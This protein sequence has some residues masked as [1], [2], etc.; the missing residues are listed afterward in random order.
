MDSGAK[1]YSNKANANGNGAGVYVTYG[2]TLNIKNG[3]E[4]YSNSADSGN[5]NGGGVYNAG[6]VYM[7]GGLVYDNSAQNGG[8][9]SGGGALIMSGG[10]I[11]KNSSGTSKPNTATNAGGAIY[12]SGSLNMSG[13]ALVCAGS[14]K[15]NDVYLP[16]GKTVYVANT[17]NEANVATVTLENWTRGTN[18]L[19]SLAE[20]RSKMVAAK[21]KFTLSKDPDGWNKL[22]D[23][24]TST[25][26]TRYAWIS[27]PMY[28]A[29]SSDR[30]VCSAPP[31]S[32]NNG[33]KT[34]PYGSIAA[35]LAAT[36]LA[37]VENTITIDGTLSAQ[38]I[39]STVTLPTGVTAVTLQGY[40]AADATT[41]AA[42]IDGG[43]TTSALA[44]GKSTTYTI[45][46][47]QITNGSAY[48]GGGINIAAGTVNLDS[49]ALV[50][51]NKAKA[52]GT[53]KGRGAGVY[54]DTDST[55]TMKN[56][57]GKTTSGEISSNTASLG[58]AV[59]MDWCGSSSGIK[60]YGAASIPKGSDEKND[61][62]VNAG[63]ADAVKPMISTYDTLTNSTIS[64]ITGNTYFYEENY[65]IIK[66][67]G[68]YN[69]GNAAKMEIKSEN[70]QDWTI[71]TSSSAGKLAKAKK[72]TSSNIASF[73]PT[74]STSYN[75]VIDS[76]VTSTQMKTFLEALCNEEVNTEK[77]KIAGNSI[78]DL[79]KS[80]LT[81]IA[82][83]NFG[84]S[85][86]RKYVEQTFA[87][88]ILPSTN[89]ASMLADYHVRECLSAK[90]YVVAPGSTTMC[91]D[92]NGVV[93][94]ADK[95]KII[96]YPAASTNT[97]YSWP[98]TV[99][100]V[101]GYAF[102]LVKNLTAVTI[103]N[104]VKTIGISAFQEAKITSVTV[105]SSVTSMGIQTF[106][107]CKQL[108]SATVNNTVV[109][110]R[111]FYGCSNLTNV[112]LYN[113]TK[114]TGASFEASG[115]KS[116]TIPATV[117]YIGLYGLTNNMTSL[118]FEKTDKWKSYN[119]VSDSSETY[120]GVI[121]STQLNAT[122]YNST[123]YNKV[124]KYGN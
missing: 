85:S 4:I 66:F 65:Q 44:I 70:S 54:L 98:N 91:T 62:Y 111:E 88:V 99:T 116:I 51:S 14:E 86:N 106:W 17:L 3:S 27:S 12:N 82:S 64:L 122:N 72:L 118:T 92:N 97:S 56:A 50:F 80:G 53:T 120:E 58:G 103:P 33:T 107:G 55:L 20:N 102:A 74:A 67:L 90:E 123:W 83:M 41:S 95:T 28:V 21:S 31:G 71:V 68:T 29:G 25:G 42:K 77:I 76:T 104:T 81:S 37:Q 49:G 40:K 87:K 105:P 30:V 112:I 101:A 1:V 78:L 108:T 47:L 121:S 9:F 124:L 94:N 115:L 5:I 6:T 119:Y 89:C 16:S 43:A 52:N 11:G 15:T 39:A 59:Y 7:T 38:T 36:D 23:S 8:A 110:Q 96:Y 113:V 2:A 60:L 69:H 114:I 24:T 61:I 13:D 48:D 22:D 18:F 32:G 117:T 10:A 84:N 34:S 57:T 93:Y 19:S 26:N 63:P 35:A 79:S 73:T 100:E 45:K 109:S 75:F 46:D